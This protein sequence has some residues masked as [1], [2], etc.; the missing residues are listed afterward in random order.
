MIKTSEA[1]K[2]ATEK[3]KE[4]NRDRNKCLNYKSTAKNFIR[5]HATQDDLNELR[6]LIDQREAEQKNSE[7]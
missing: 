5:N 6:V 7:D 2:R 1:Q 3:W 4:K